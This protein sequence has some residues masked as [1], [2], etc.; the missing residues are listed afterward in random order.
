M[1]SFLFSVSVVCSAVNADLIMDGFYDSYTD[2]NRHNRLI[3]D[4][5]A[6]DLDGCDDICE[7]SD[8]SV[9]SDD[10]T[11][12]G[13][14]SL[15]KTDVVPYVQ[16]ENYS[17]SKRD[18]SPFRGSYDICDCS[19]SNCGDSVKFDDNVVMDVESLEKTESPSVVIAEES[20]GSK[21]SPQEIDKVARGAKAFF[22]IYNHPELYNGD[23]MN[24][25][26]Q[27]SIR[28]CSEIFNKKADDEIRE[29]KESKGE[30][31]VKV[32]ADYL[33]RETEAD[34]AAFANYIIN[35]WGISDTD[36]FIV[37]SLKRIA[38]R[39]TLAMARK[40]FEMN[41]NRGS[42]YEYMK[43][44]NGNL[45]VAYLRYFAVW[46]DGIMQLFKEKEQKRINA[47]LE[48]EKVDV[49]GVGVS[50]NAGT[51][52]VNSKLLLTDRI[53]DGLKTAHGNTKHFSFKS[54]FANCI[55]KFKRVIESK[56][57]PDTVSTF[58]FLKKCGKKLCLFCID[59]NIRILEF[60]RDQIK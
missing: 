25:S 24:E 17:E 45:D 20:N 32:D 58:S 12:I 39:A 5:V 21:F 28:E 3:C 6:D 47:E 50:Q 31:Y 51:H 7:I 41:M 44:S 60:I 56:I 35:N 14:G 9:R 40:R 30:V 11:L 37:A 34:P 53:V 16:Y 8:D 22:M 46:N 23:F 36:S 26:M 48:S 54:E 1:R 43:N 38:N 2:Y 52:S 57:M 18:I 15:E 42:E 13:K 29:E 33:V 49:S 27:Q 55:D 4:S 59:T 19:V 10:D